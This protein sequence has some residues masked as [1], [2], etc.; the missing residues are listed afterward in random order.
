VGI[1]YPHCGVYI[2]Q[3][4]TYDESSVELSKCMEGMTNHESGS[5]SGNGA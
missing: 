4:N 1:R 3:G 2:V 5:W